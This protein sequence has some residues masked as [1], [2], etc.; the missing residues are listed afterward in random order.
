MS[1]M[2]PAGGAHP[3]S[4]PEEIRVHRALCNASLTSDWRVIQ[5]LQLQP[6]GG[7]AEGE[8]DFLVLVPGR[9]WVVL[10][11]KGHDRIVQ[12]EGR[13]LVEYGR[14]ESKAA[15]L[16]A[17]G[18]E[19]AIR[20][21]L[22]K[23]AASSDEGRDF[24]CMSTWMIV[25]PN[26]QPSGTLCGSPSYAAEQVV[27]AD[28]LG[29]ELSN[30]PALILRALEVEGS[31]H[32]DPPE[33]SPW[34]KLAGMSFGPTGDVCDRIVELLS[35][36]PSE[37]WSDQLLA[38]QSWLTEEQKSVLTQLDAKWGGSGCLV[39]G[40]AGTG[41]TILARLE[42]QRCAARGLRTL[43]VVP[44]DQAK[45]ECASISKKITVRTL[46]ELAWVYG[47]APGSESDE[48]PPDLPDYSALELRLDLGEV[49]SG[50]DAI[51]ADEFQQALFSC[52]ARVLLQL[53]DALLVGGLQ[54][55][56]WR[57]FMDQ[58]QA[59][60]GRSRWGGIAVLVGELR[61]YFGALEE[62]VYDAKKAEHPE[63][64]PSDAL[65]DAATRDSLRA[66]RV[67]MHEWL[68]DYRA[69]DLD[70]DRYCTFLS[71][72][73][74]ERDPHARKVMAEFD[75]RKRAWEWRVIESLV[76]RAAMN[77][78]A[79]WFG[80]DLRLSELA[81]D[82]VLDPY[83]HFPVERLGVCCRSVEGIA[84]LA[85]YFCMARPVLAYEEY[86][87]LRY[88][89]D[90]GGSWSWGAAPLHPAMAGAAADLSARGVP[91][92]DLYGS[93]VFVS[94]GGAESLATAVDRAAMMAAAHLG[95]DSCTPASPQDIAFISLAEERFSPH[96]TPPSRLVSLEMIQGGEARVV[97]V[98]VPAFSLSLE[99][100][101]EMYRAIGRARELV[102]LVFDPER[103]H[104]WMDGLFF[105]DPYDG[106]F[107]ERI[108]S[109]PR[110]LWHATN[111][112]HVPI[113]EVEGRDM[114]GGTQKYLEYDPAPEHTYQQWWMRTVAEQEYCGPALPLNLDMLE[115]KLR[116]IPPDPRWPHPLW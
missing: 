6:H 73:N 70:V 109:D 51:I 95:L 94:Y 87:Y 30:L 93:V 21:W 42:A 68:A 64:V 60:E 72:E 102:I 114:E 80:S 85:D 33:G 25:A 97:V 31:R 106:E 107:D 34:A 41:K 105:G 5:S 37:S 89:Y 18:N 22:R 92:E 29:N 55:G 52:D 3:G 76:R 23:H 98:I 48:A 32:K 96:W 81:V 20:H 54:A 110:W 35:P 116:V 67:E 113:R 65:I 1:L 36:G 39:E 104:G 82:S 57:G 111:D 59:P 2:V 62:W 50:F 69:V 83:G 28:E 101:G 86:I 77:E 58:H 16:Q 9:G 24:L 27:G 115:G 8:A 74:L 43:L 108:G 40:A 84:R 7:K 46:D 99:W 56:R 13:I 61:E 44:N 112:W 100:C 14:G 45:V 103:S 78:G 15:N 19:R 12:R 75:R 66:V 53:L 90:I 26:W 10:E 71:G 91:D 63:P 47:I 4:T 11:V 38:K 17:Q 88:D 49:D 79:V